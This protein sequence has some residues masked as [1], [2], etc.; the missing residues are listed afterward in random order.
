M[1]PHT[2][3]YRLQLLVALVALLP[4]VIVAALSLFWLLPQSREEM[5]SHHQEM[6]HSITFQI[7]DHLQGT[8]REIKSLADVLWAQT[9]APTRVLD[10]ILDSHVATGEFF[11]AIYLTSWEDTVLSVGLPMERRRQRPDLLGI[12]LSRR[13]FIQK[14]RQTGLAGWSNTFLS[15]VSGSL[16]IAYAVP[17]DGQILVGEIAAGRL[18]KY[19]SG[20]P[21]QARQAIAVLDG[22]KQVIAYSREVFAERHLDLA[23]PGDMEAWLFSDQAMKSFSLAGQRYICTEVPVKRLGWNIVTAQLRGEALKPLFSTLWMLIIGMV[24]ALAASIMAGWFISRKLTSDFSALAGRARAIAQGNYDRVRSASAIREFAD[25]EGDLQ[26]MSSAIRRREKDLAESEARLLKAQSVGRVGTWELNLADGT[27]W[28]SAEVFNI[29]GLPQNESQTMSREDLRN[30][31][32]PDHNETLNKALG[33][34]FNKGTPF[35][36]EYIIKR[37]SD[38][39]PRY[40]HTKAELTFSADGKPEKVIGTVQD[41][42]SR[43]LAEQALEAS[44]SLLL[45]SQAVAR[46]GH[47]RLDVTA[48]IWDSS[49]ILNEIL[50]LEPDHPKNLENWLAVIHPEDRKELEF[51]IENMAAGETESF[52]REF[53]VV[54][55]NDGATR[56]VHGLGRLEFDSEGRPAELIGTVQDITEHKELE[57]QLLHSQKMEA[58]GMLAGGVAHDFNNM[59]AVILGY[60]ELM[61]MRMPSDTPHYDKLAAIEEAAI[62]SRDITR[63][64]LAFSRKQIIAPKPQN[65]TALIKDT[66]KTLTRLIGEDVRLTFKPVEDVWLVKMDP[67]QVDQIL[68]NLAVNA[69]DAMTAGGDMMIEL[70]NLILDEGFCRHHSEAKPGN[71]VMLAVSDTGHGMDKT[72]VSRIFE[73]FFTTKEVGKGTGLGLATVYGIVKQNGGFV[74]VYSEVDRG[75]TFRIY[76]PRYKGEKQAEAAEGMLLPKP[77][78]G[79]ILLVEDEDLMREVVASQLETLGYTV[80]SFKRPKDAVNLIKGGGFPFDLLVTD[81][82]MPGMNGKELRETIKDILPDIGVLFM[83]GYTRDVIVQHGVLE[84]GVHFLAKPFTLGDLALSV[85][86]AMG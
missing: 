59:L 19:I 2:L 75:T 48:G 25:L 57:Q 76:L 26:K 6:A 37:K 32:A 58:I 7:V 55:V 51:I 1:R 17:M 60:T 15:T 81:V 10:S 61:R 41:I 39:E 27:V 43:K 33:D 80:T 35:D 28:G 54:R 82:I 44:N 50:G 34:L 74:T 14:I 42:T 53:R 9:G 11:T 46:L 23:Q 13:R 8:E 70:A 45:E 73:P 22:R 65:L 78:S 30:T 16:A 83:S 4:L 3:R 24:S 63:Q 62:R 49:A 38:S 29:Y 68:V 12:D 21:A 84:Q 66:L 77:G 52:D 56:W 79:D 67:S 36:I 86:K 40:L 85:R 47:Y 69:R 5:S 20:I 64:L 72:T 18:T 31:L 71:Y